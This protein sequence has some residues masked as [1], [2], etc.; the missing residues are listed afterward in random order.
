MADFFPILRWSQRI[1]RR[2]QFHVDR[3]FEIAG[4]FIKER[5]E[6]MEL[7][8]EVEEEKRKD[9]LDVLLE[10]RGDGAEE[11]SKFT[12]RIINVINYQKKES[13]TSSSL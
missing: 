6:S 10:F 1:R 3:A 13:S 7:Q 9:F 12:S 11:P 2:M 4:H 8:G 5:M